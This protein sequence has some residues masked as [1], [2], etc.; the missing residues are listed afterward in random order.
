MSLPL[1]EL[2]VFVY[3]FLDDAGG[4][5]VLPRP[6]PLRVPPHPQVVVAL[7]PNAAA[8]AVELVVEPLPLVDAVAALDDI[9]PDPLGLPFL[10]QLAD[11]D[12]V[13]VLELSEG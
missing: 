10:V 3:A 12:S 13:C 2:I 1:V 4:E 9:P 11:V 5:Y 6:F 8:V 7:R